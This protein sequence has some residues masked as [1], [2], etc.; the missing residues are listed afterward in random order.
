MNALTCTFE[1]GFCNWKNNVSTN[2]LPWQRNRG[3]TPSSNTG[4]SF[5]H[6][7][8]NAFGKLSITDY[9]HSRLTIL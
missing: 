2:V 9:I 7:L 4:P 6:T 1:R 8:G 5:D 3:Q